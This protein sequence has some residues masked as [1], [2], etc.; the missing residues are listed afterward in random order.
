MKSNTENTINEVAKLLLDSQR[1]LF[2]TGA[3]ISADSGLPT[4]RGVGGLY[5]GKSTEDGFAIEE[6]LGGTMMQRRPDITWKYLWQ[7]GEACHKAQPNKAHEIIA[8]IENIKPD[9]WVSTQNIDGFH[10][11]VETKNL[12]EIHG[13]A[14]SLFCSSCGKSKDYQELTAELKNELVFPPICPEC[15]GVIRPNVVL[16]GEQLPAKAINQLYSLLDSK[17]DLVV[18]I[19]TSGVFPY[20]VEPIRIANSRYKLTVEINPAET[21]ISYMFDYR[22]KLG[23]AEAMERI[24]YQIEKIL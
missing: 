24:W 13:N 21:D 10:R 1:I 14:F 18:S 5:D 17:I 6:A 23:A 9:T 16:F 8:Q 20:I 19:G 3:G 22:I 4:Y 11:D 15:N 2:I 12:I 7:I